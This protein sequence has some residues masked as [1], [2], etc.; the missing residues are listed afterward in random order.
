MSTYYNNPFNY[1]GGKYR[2]LS[3]IL[4]LI[5]TEINTYIELFSGGFTVGLNINAN[6]YIY[7]DKC[8]QLANLVHTIK[9]LPVEFIIRQVDNYIK[10][11]NLPINTKNCTEDNEI[12]YKLLRGHYNTFDFDINTSSIIFYTLLCH[13]FNNQIGFNGNGEYNI[14]IG[15]NKSTYNS[16][17]R[18]KLKIFSKRIKEID[19]QIESKDFIEFKNYNFNENDYIYIDPP[20]LISDVSYSRCPDTRWGIEKEKELL[21]FLD[22]LNDNN[23]KFGLSNIIEHNNK[24]NDFLI[25]WSSKYNVINLEKNYNNCN[26]QFKGKTS[27]TQE[28]FITNYKRDLTVIENINNS[29]EIL[30]SNIDKSKLSEEHKRKISEGLK[31]SYLLRKNNS[32]DKNSI[33]E[34]NSIEDN[35]IEDNSIEDNTIEDNSIEDNSIEDNSIEDNSIEDNNISNTDNSSIEDIYLN[36]L[37]S[38]ELARNNVNN[39]NTLRFISDSIKAESLKGNS[40]INFN[41]TFSLEIVD[42][43]KKLGYNIFI[44][45]DNILIS[46]E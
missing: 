28:V 40:K 6:R 46:W 2:L 12:G 30:Q 38:A 33:I 4:P 32:S 43:I 16:S 25:E 10:E 15:R 5:P 22:Y 13:S 20:Y 3:Q 39:I 18:E 31:K 11:Y 14:P 7:N 23:I 1:I 26:Y 42:I 8:H 27:Q 34:D 37:F 9:D 45:E 29:E 21:E 35:S 19:L 24:K 36:N 41:V 44:N 17:L